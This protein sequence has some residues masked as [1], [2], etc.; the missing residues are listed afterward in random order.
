MNACILLMLVKYND[1]VFSEDETSLHILV[2]FFLI[3][4]IN[5]LYI[6]YR[7]YKYKYI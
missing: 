7:Y 2:C 4:N 1:D 5:R 6:Y 3:R